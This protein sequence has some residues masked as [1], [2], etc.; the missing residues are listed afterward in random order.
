VRNYTGDHKRTWDWFARFAKGDTTL[1]GSLVFDARLGTTTNGVTVTARSGAKPLGM[2]EW[3]LMGKAK[4]G[5]GN[6]ATGVG[7]D[8]PVFMASA[9]DWMVEVGFAWECVFSHNNGLPNANEWHGIGPPDGDF[10]NYPTA[11]KLFGVEAGKVYAAKI[12]ALAA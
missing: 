11:P 8:N 9:M 5:L 7:G 10:A 12:A 2:H 6:P 1:T 4:D 3:G